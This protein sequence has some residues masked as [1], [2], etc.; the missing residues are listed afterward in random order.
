MSKGIGLILIYVLPK[1]VKA[2]AQHG[3]NPIVIKRE[4]DRG[5]AELERDIREMD[6]VG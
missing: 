3:L 2:H 6:R 5:L 4:M 1:V